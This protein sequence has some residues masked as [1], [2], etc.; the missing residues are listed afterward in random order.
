MS[1]SL[2]SSSLSLLSL[3]PFP[4]SLSLSQAEDGAGGRRSRR[5]PAAAAGV[6]GAAP[7]REGEQ[8]GGALEDTID[9]AIHVAAAD[10]LDALRA[11]WDG[12]A[13]RLY[14]ALVILPPPLAT[15][16]QAVYAALSPPNAVLRLLASLPC[17]PNSFML[18]T[19]LSALASS[20]DPASTLGLFSLSAVTAATAAAA[21]ARTRLTPS[22]ARAY[23]KGEEERKS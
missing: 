4:L 2:L 16:P 23:G 20:P 22:R 14:T 19:T 3:L 11:R 13:K 12:I 6:V 21:A 8:R 15:A 7:P 5:A 9:A 1:V 18:N 10:H 17:A